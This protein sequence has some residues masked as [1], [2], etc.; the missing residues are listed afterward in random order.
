[1]KKGIEYRDVTR[2]IVKVLVKYEAT[3]LDVQRI[4]EGLNAEMIVSP[5]ENQ[6]D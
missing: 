5:V 2:E 4:V 1:M 6:T 3:V